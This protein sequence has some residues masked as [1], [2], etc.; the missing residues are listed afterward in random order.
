MRLVPSRSALRNEGIHSKVDHVNANIQ[1]KY[2]YEY[3]ISCINYFPLFLRRI[4]IHDFSALVFQLFLKYIYTGQINDSENCTSE[5]L[6]DLIALA[7]K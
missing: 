4:V 7:D 1:Y 6:T 3:L 2:E 5:T